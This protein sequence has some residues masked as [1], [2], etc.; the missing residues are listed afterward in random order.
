VRDSFV[1]FDIPAPSETVAL[2]MQDGAQIR[3]RRYGN[4]RGARLVLSHGNGLAINSYAPFWL[5]LTGQFDVIV[6]D[7]RNHGENPRH[8]PDRHQ[9]D[10]IIEDFEEIFQAIQ[11]HFGAAPTTGV[12]HSLSAIA[13]LQHALRYGPRWAALA[14]F[15]PPIYPKDGHPL[16]AA[17]NADM[18][19]HVQR[20]NRRPPRYD[21]PEEFAGQLAR[22]PAFARLI[23]EGAMLLARH[24]LRPGA[25]GGWELGN[26]RELEAR[27]YQAQSDATLWP[28]MRDLTIP[29]IMICGDP[30]VP[31]TS[32]ATRV[33]AAI[34]EDIGIEYVAIAD[35]THFLQIESPQ[36]CRDALLS[37]LERHDLF[38]DKAGRLPRDNP[39][40]AGAG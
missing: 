14:L 9:M 10:A 19:A 35:T 23:P 7:V 32:P 38:A 13:S 27:I 30:A 24:T 34:H 22:R 2:V 5:P 36:A 31:E 26:L 16:Q 4:P 33:G 6:F 29:V 15:D 18:V 39:D 12:F 8:E 37:F 17:H 1:E 40:V 3:L 21:R 28:R 25:D 20:S 11:T